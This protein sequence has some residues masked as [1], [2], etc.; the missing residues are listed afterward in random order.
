MGY[1]VVHQRTS[2]LTG[3]II[4]DNEVV[5]VAL[6]S[7]GKVFDA[8]AAELSGLKLLSNVVE[9]EYR[10][11]DKE[12]ESVFCTEAELAKLIPADKMEK[13]DALKGRRTGYSP[14]A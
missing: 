2:D 10:Y 1:Q 12:P 5:T 8:T 4:P 9:L 11:P 7:Q 13:F 6:R 3:E 14:R